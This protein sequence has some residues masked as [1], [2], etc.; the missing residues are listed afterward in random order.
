MPISSCNP[1][2]RS[3]ICAW[4]VTSSAV[5]GSSAISSAGRQANAIAIIA[6]CRM[7]PGKLVRI[8]D[9]ALLG[10]CD[11]YGCQ[12]IHRARSSLPP[13][14][15]LVQ[16]HHF[17][18]LAT[19]LHHRV[20]R[21]HWLLEHHRDTFAAQ[22][23]PHRGGLPQ[24]LAPLDSDRPGDP[25]RRRYQSH[26]GQRRHRLAAA[27][28]SHHAQRPAGGHAEADAGHHLSQTAGHGGNRPTGPRRSERH[29]SAVQP[30]TARL[31]G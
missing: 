14:Q 17:G 23:P 13:R 5:V 12:G 3:M 27:A 1:S 2:M 18:D 8:G 6:R 11:A 20:Q 16:H 21:R 10:R 26:D 29:S 4:I 28:L 19:D 15:V 9:S 31:L 25:A 22:V 24:H 30:S 7:P